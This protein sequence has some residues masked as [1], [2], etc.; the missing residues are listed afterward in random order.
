[1]TQVE[2]SDRLE[3][4]LQIRHKT[5]R[6]S[7][8]WICGDIVIR[9]RRVSALEY[10]AARIDRWRQEFAAAESTRL[11]AVFAEMEAKEKEALEGAEGAN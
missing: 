3:T 5:F 4:F 7:L 11:G 6:F 1:M 9:W 8:R 2:R 10:N